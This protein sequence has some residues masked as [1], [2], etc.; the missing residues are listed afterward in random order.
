VES[1][2]GAFT[3][4]GFKRP[5]YGLGGI[6]KLVP[7]QTPLVVGRQDR[8]ALTTKSP[9][10]ISAV[11]THRSALAYVRSRRLAAIHR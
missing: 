6:W 11:P 5:S 2:A 7:A 8:R 10:V 9:A 3:G 1:R 4:L